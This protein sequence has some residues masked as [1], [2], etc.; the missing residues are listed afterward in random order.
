MNTDFHALCAELLQPLAEY[1]DAN[2]YHEHRALIA[3][4]RAALVQPEGEGPGEQ[5][6]DAFIHQWWEAFG[7]G[8]PPNSSDKA[9][10]TAALARWGRPVAP[11]APE[12]AGGSINDEQ[13]EAVREAVA[14]ALGNAYDCHRVWE[15]WGVGTMGS[16]D[17]SLVAE[18]DN[19]VAEIADAAIEA[20]RPSAPP[21]SEPGEGR[22]SEGICGDGAAILCD[23]AM[24][25]VEEVEA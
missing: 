24:V 22:W 10:I 25:P 15:A 6:I 21:A 14:Q 8:F 11:P 9:L 17:F 7:K 19:R 18:D 23:G 3:R 4:A 1:D 12:H 16:D 2:P 13:R 5:E 20:M